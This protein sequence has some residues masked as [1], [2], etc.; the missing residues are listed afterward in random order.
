M[1]TAVAVLQPV[2]RHATMASF[3]PGVRIRLGMNFKYLILLNC[4]LGSRV[5]DKVLGSVNSNHNPKHIY[6]PNPNPTITLIL[7]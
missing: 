1:T 7:T 6:N 5:R 4:G 2:N 3:F